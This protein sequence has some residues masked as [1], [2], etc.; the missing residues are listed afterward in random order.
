MR[1]G[2]CVAGLVFAFASALANAAEPALEVTGPDG[3]PVQLALRDGEAALIVHFWASWGPECVRE[4]PTLARVAAR[5][6]A[7]HVGAVNVMTARPGGSVLGTA[8]A[9][10]CCATPRASF[11]DVWRGAFRQT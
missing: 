11:G 3:A 5:C 7:V 2:A 6:A 9:S 10:R 4:L 8:P 1:T